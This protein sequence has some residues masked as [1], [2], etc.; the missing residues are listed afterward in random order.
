MRQ[1]N[2]LRKITVIIVEH[3][4]EM[5]ANADHVIEMGPGAGKY[6]GKI[7]YQGPPLG[8]LTSATSVTGPFFGGTD[9]RET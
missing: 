9:V 4:L 1:F 7:I 6:G 8:M 5:I 3:N 2:E